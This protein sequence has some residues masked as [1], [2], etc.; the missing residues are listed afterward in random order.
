MAVFCIPPQISAEKR[1]C[2]N[3]YWSYDV[4]IYIYMIYRYIYDTYMS[5]FSIG[6]HEAMVYMSFFG[7]ESFD[8]KAHNKQPVL[9]FARVCHKFYTFLGYLDPVSMCIT[10]TSKFWGDLTD[11]SAKFYSL[12]KVTELERI[13]NVKALS[14]LMRRTHVV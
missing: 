2:L 5:S 9:L 12:Q 10:K 1:F 11:A 7:N 14:E 6:L 4:Y 3:D 8:I 13:Q